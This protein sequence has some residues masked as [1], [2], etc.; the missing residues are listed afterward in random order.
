RAGL[1]GKAVSFCDAEERE[2]LKDIQKLIS[3]RIPLVNDHPY[4]AL[5]IPEDGKGKPKPKLQTARPQNPNKP[6]V[7]HTRTP[8]NSNATG[9]SSRTESG[10]RKVE[11]APRRTENTQKRAE[12]APRKT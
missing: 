9:N 3:I 2:Y 12:N 5:N 4:P 11:P 8:V 6:K 7:N 10:L 1:E